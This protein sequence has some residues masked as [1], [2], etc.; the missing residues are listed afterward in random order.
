MQALERVRN[1]ADVQNRHLAQVI[2]EMKLRHKEELEDQENDLRSLHA[3]ELDKLIKANGELKSLYKIQLETASVNNQKDIEAFR[4]ELETF[5]QKKL[6]DLLQQKEEEFRV[7]RGKEMENMERENQKE[8]EK[9]RSKHVEDI[10]DIERFVESE[11]QKQIK[12]LVDKH[13]SELADF[14]EELARKGSALEMAEKRLLKLGEERKTEMDRLNEIHA[15]ELNDMRI[16]YDLQNERS[17]QSNAERYE[18][19]IKHLRNR[20][21]A[22]EATIEEL[23]IKGKED[24]LE[25][26]HEQLENDLVNQRKQVEELEKRLLESQKEKD[27]IF[28]EIGL[29]HEK[30]INELRLTLTKDCNRRIEELH[31]SHQHEIERVQGKM[32]KSQNSAALMQQKYASELQ[33]RDEEIADANAKHVQELG[34]LRSQLQAENEKQFRDLS[35]KYEDGFEALRTELS[36]KND[37]VKNM[38]NRHSHEM[39][40]MKIFVDQ[41]VQDRD[42]ILGNARRDIKM[43]ENEMESLKG[44][45]DTLQQKLKDQQQRFEGDILRERDKIKDLETKHFDEIEDLKRQHRDYLNDSAA[46][47]RQEMSRLRTELCAGSDLLKDLNAEHSR[48]ISQL[49]ADLEKRRYHGGTEAELITGC[50]ENPETFEPEYK[51]KFN[52]DDGRYVNSNG[53]L[54]HQKL[55][56]ENEAFRRLIK[57]CIEDFEAKVSRQRSERS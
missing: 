30:K 24:K 5:H 44:D 54:E 16:E 17:L 15:K 20:L 29:T 43:N 33:E 14:D 49:K 21:N 25:K 55:L 42:Q 11:T 36:R 1:E 8:I 23:N 26:K 57:D 45:L 46:E 53:T 13:R 28:E 41:L 32:K 51:E 52:G 12:K 4:E 40:D 6:S 35:G 37:L 31:R 2:D 34:I 56:E 47:Y 10:D 48:E 39:D 38:E 27:R 50:P 18:K 22:T 9:L 3:R 7:Q 19:E